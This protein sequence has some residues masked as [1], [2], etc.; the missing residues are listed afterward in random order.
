MM[1]FSK[2]QLMIIA[3]A[4]EIRD[5]EV[6]FVGMRL[7]ITAFGVA[8][9]THA[10]NAVGLFEC[11]IVRN[12]PAKE[13]LYTM[14]DPPNQKEAAW[15]SGLVQVMGLLQGGRVDAGFIGGAEIDLFGNI[16]SSYIG[17]HSQPKV[18]LPGSGGAADIAALSGRLIA[19]MNHESRRLVEKV[20]YVTSTGFLEGCADRE[21]KGLKGGP[22]AL[23]TDLGV[24]KPHGT[25]HE[26]H[27]SSFHPGNDPDE[28]ISQTGW[29]LQLKPDIKETPHPTSDELK[30]LSQIDPDGFWS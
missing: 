27:L 28:V 3:A 22:S 18:K 14:A 6:V 17:S 12:Q 24:L 16:N 5:H 21:K 30:A 15:C 29:D 2:Q 8:K 13:M 19:I 9:L 26:L 23:I 10:P 4:R 25:Q 20:Q 1:N 7:P 11:G